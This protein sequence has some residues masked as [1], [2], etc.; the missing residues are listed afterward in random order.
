MNDCLRR[1]VY[2]T[3][4]KVGQYPCPM[5][6]VD[7]STGQ[8]YTAANT[9]SG[10]DSFDQQSM[11]ATL[12]GKNIDNSL[13]LDS[14][15]ML[16]AHIAEAHPKFNMDNYFVCKQCGQV[17]LNRYKLSCHLFN[18]HSGKRK[19]RSTTALAQQQ[20]NAAAAGANKIFVMSNPNAA[21]FSLS[22]TQLAN[23]SFNTNEVKY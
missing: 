21:T 18:V 10:T 12:L 16:R 5:C 19:R 3:L 17:F 9:Q 4:Q 20:Q 11:I 7:E 14:Y 1:H 15:D 2:V 8:V 6:Q 13:Y 22:H 23:S